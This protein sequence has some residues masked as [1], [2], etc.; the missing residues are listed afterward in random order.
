M[1]QDLLMFYSVNQRCYLTQV[2]Y[3][4]SI[5]LMIPKITKD[6][7]HCTA[8]MSGVKRC[9]MYVSP[10]A[11]P[12]PPT[13]LISLSPY[14]FFSPFSPSHL[15]SAHAP[16]L[17]VLLL[18]LCSDYSSIDSHAD[19]AIGRCADLALDTH[20]R[21]C[22]CL[23]GADDLQVMRSVFVLVS[24]RDAFVSTAFRC[25]KDVQS[26]KTK[27]K[28]SQQI[29]MNHF[30]SYVN[31]FVPFLPPTWPCLL[32]CIYRLIIPI[33]QTG[34]TSSHDDRQTA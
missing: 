2:P 15:H 24:S 3:V 23:R 5:T 9:V 20:N 31:F 1:C 30:E 27:L 32:V 13:R 21:P 25:R 19:V 18:H 22:R 26:V 6:F 4:I 16:L 11:P 7:S 34:Q 14:P 17:C 12:H 8:S 33:Q 10:F 28:S 29:F